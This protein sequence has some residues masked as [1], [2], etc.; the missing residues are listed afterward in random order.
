MA[1]EWVAF[2]PSIAQSHPVTPRPTMIDFRPFVT[3]FTMLM[4]GLQ[5]PYGMP[6]SMM[7]DL[8]TNLSIFTNNVA[9]TYSPLLASGSFIGNLGQTMQP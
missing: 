9:N 6:T 1:Q 8:N 4:L 5:E 7:D 2:S 3:S